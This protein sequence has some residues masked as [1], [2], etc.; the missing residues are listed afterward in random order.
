VRPA[1][2]AA[3]HAARPRRGLALF[4]TPVFWSPAALSGIAP[5]LAWIE[6]NPFH[7]LLGAWRA[8]LIGQGAFPWASLGYAA[9]WALG[10]LITGHAI[11]RSLRPEFADE[12]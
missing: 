7:H 12:V 5:W 3:R 9:C 1:G 4:A 8:V 10:A 11:F 6:A 2:R